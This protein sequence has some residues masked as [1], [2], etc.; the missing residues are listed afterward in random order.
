VDRVSGSLSAFIRVRVP[1]L[2]VCCGYCLFHGYRDGCHYRTLPSD[3][4]SPVRR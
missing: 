2:R 1:A 3:L 4:Q